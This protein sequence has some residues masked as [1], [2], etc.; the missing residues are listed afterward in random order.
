M[1]TA[2]S[3]AGAS[4]KVNERLQPIFQALFEGKYTLLLPEALLVGLVVVG[5]LIFRI[6]RRHQ[7]ALA[8]IGNSQ[9][10][11]SSP[12]IT[13]AP[14]VEIGNEEASRIQTTVSDWQRSSEVAYLSVFDNL[15]N[16]L[17]QSIKIWPGT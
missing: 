12:P 11:T 15:L 17:L 1:A 2:N 16:T 4:L 13:R 9:Q 5:L 7:H 10:P 8:I 14:S 6:A 3:A